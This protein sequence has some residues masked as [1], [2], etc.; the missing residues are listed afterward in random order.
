MKVGR[1]KGYAFRPSFDIY[2][3]GEIASSTLNLDVTSPVNVQKPGL[4]VRLS[5]QGGIL[6]MEAHMIDWCNKCQPD[7]AYSGRIG[8]D[9]NDGGLSFEH[10]EKLALVFEKLTTNAFK[11]V[12]ANFKVKLPTPFLVNTNKNN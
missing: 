9:R 5:K 7:K 12:T 8:Y 10:V 11:P 4:L 6:S 2:I 3:N 1:Y